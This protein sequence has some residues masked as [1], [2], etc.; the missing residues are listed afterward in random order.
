MSLLFYFTIAN[1]LSNVSVFVGHTK[2]TPFL[3]S[4][5]PG[6]SVSGELI[7][8]K[9]DAPIPGRYVKI[10]INFISEFSIKGLNDIDL[11]E[12]E[13]YARVIDG[14]SYPTFYP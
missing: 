2:E 14:M 8:R 3:C 13:V 10:S 11:C 1:P 6:P 4:F 7:K 12:V 9:C 5:Y